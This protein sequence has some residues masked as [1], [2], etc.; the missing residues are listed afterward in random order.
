MGARGGMIALIK[1][2]L[3]SLKGDYTPKRRRMDESSELLENIKTRCYFD[4]ELNIKAAD[5]EP[6]ITYGTNPEWELV[7]LKVS[8]CK[9]SSRW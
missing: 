6:M 2:H 9:S 8:E 5:I 3:I 4:S 7:F 1:K